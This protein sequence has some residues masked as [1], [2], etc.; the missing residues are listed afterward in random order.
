MGACAGDNRSTCFSSPR[1]SLQVFHSKNQGKNIL[2]W[3]LTKKN[4]AQINKEREGS[5]L[6]LEM[7]YNEPLDNAGISGANPTYNL[8]WIPQKLTACSWLE[9]LESIFCMYYILYYNRVCRKKENGKENTFIVLYVFIETN[10]HSSNLYC[11]RISCLW[12]E[13]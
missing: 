11:I 7:Y 10:P 6:E 13:W 5:L 12:W 8:L 4:S 3:G 9:A 1:S 2:W